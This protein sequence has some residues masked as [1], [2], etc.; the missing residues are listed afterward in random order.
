M[1]AI[2][3]KM[4]EK[5]YEINCNLQRKSNEKR[6][7]DSQEITEHAYRKM[8]GLSPNTAA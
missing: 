4:N 6:S 5:D 2:L 1:F 7:V 3:Y 8:Y